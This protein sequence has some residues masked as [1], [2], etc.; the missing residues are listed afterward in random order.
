MFLVTDL[1][2][3]RIATEIIMELTI[4]SILDKYP[5]LTKDYKINLYDEYLLKDDNL[6]VFEKV[7]EG[8]YTG[9]YFFNSRGRAAIEVA[10]LLV[11]KAFSSFAEVIQGLTPINQKGAK[12]LTLKLGAKSYGIVET[13]N[14]PCELFIMTKDEWRKKWDF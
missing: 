1:V 3:L 13:I 11:Q 6:M 7:K 2:G 4:K 9:H 8:I 12:W 14:G 10:Q 5:T